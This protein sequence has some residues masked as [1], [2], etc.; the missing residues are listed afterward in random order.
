[1]DTFQAVLDAM[2]GELTDDKVGILLIMLCGDRFARPSLTICMVE[3][4]TP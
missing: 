4:V 3:V 2:K 1:M